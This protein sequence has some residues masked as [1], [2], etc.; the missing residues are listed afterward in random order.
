VPFAIVARVRGG[1]IVHLKDYGNKVLALEAAG[2]S[3]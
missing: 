3:E 2:L 1:L